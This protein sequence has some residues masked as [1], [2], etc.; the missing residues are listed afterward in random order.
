M[1]GSKAVGQGLKDGTAGG[2]TGATSC[3]VALARDGSAVDEIVWAATALTDG[4][5]G[6]DLAADCE[7]LSTVTW[8]ASTLLVGAD[9]P[10]AF[11]DTWVD[12]LVSDCATGSVGAG[13][14]AVAV[15]SG[16]SAT[17]VVTASLV[18]VLSAVVELV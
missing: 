6:T 13:G 2:G 1:P 3:V 17:L 4:G 12:A 11:T 14:V 8:T 5:S 10:L 15:G 18:S 7:S 16:A 9:A